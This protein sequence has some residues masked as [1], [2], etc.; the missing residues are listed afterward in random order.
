ML[1]NY[2][3]VAFRYRTEVI[4]RLSS[5]LSI[6][7]ACMG[8]FGLATLTVVQR[9]KEIGIR[10][11]LGASIAGIVSLLS[12]DFIRPIAI[13][14]AIAFPIS[15]W[16]MNNWLDNFAYHTLVSWWL[17]LAA[18]AVALLIAGVTVSVQSIRAALNNPIISLRSE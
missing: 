3:K 7:I 6:F 10:K 4:I 17:L 11:V 12:K 16:A 15:W 8:L 18:G 2:F 9:T 13:A 14:A 1:K 5:V